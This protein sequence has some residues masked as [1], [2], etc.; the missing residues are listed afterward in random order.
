MTTIQDLHNILSDYKEIKKKQIEKRLDLHNIL[1]DYKEIKKKQIEK[2]L[3]LHK[4]HLEFQ[5][6]ASKANVPYNTKPVNMLSKKERRIRFGR[7][8]RIQK[9]QRRIRGCQKALVKVANEP[10]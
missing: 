9:I 1:S 10:D 8:E 2:R 5:I 4:T 7:L 3:D 6:E